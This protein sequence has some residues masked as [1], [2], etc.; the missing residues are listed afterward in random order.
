MDYI[1]FDGKIRII[2]VFQVASF[3]PSWES[4]YYSCLADD[5]FEVKI[6]WIDEVICGGSQ[7][8]SARQFL[9][10]MELSYDIFSYERVINFRPHY[11]IYQ[12]PYEHTQRNPY[13]W[14]A[15]YRRQGIR[16]VYI[17]YG[18]EIADTQQ[19]RYQH[20][21]LGVVLNAFNVYVLSHGIEEEYLKYCING[22][23]VRV[24]G[25]PRFDS[26]KHSERFT[27]KDEIFERAKGRKIVLWKAHFPKAVRENGVM[28]Q[29]TPKLEEYFKF[30]EYINQQKD[31]FFVFMPHPKFTDGVSDMSFKPLAEKLLEILRNSE[32]AYVD[33]SDDYRYSLMNADAIIV[34][35]SAVMVEAAAM[36]VPI[37]YMY[38]DE[39]YE[40]MTATIDELISSYYQGTSAEDMIA[41]C[42]LFKEERDERKE[43]REATFAK[44]VPFFDGKCAE[45]IKENLLR[46]AQEDCTNDIIETFDDG[47]RIIIFGAGS[48]AGRCMEVWHEKEREFSGNV[49]VLAI[50]DND[51]KK[52][53]KE[54]YDKKIISPT[55]LENIA[56]DYIVIASDMYFRDIYLQLTEELQVPKEKILTFDQFIVL[57][58]FQDDLKDNSRG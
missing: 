30:T 11:M 17:P 53:G 48:I 4:L 25:L 43:V 14:S 13:A 12:T 33:R 31:L 36:Q 55:Q 15:R 22:Q 39:F 47:C 28:K 58:S 50:V 45:R 29:V 40:P 23:A 54:Y 38:N 51:I 21:S 19:A 37:L 18:I 46:E 8:D 27:L 56:F 44:C 49:D 2:F 5:R 24:M 34:D 20:F 7:M 32:N 42:E 41:F 9:E 52:L 35:R 3:W 6:M 26:L 16:I 1:A 57:V 10:E